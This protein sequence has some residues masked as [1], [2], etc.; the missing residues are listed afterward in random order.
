M[1]VDRESFSFRIRSIT[2]GISALIGLLRRLIR[3]LFSCEIL[4]KKPLTF[5]FLS[6]R[7]KALGGVAQLVERLHGMQ[8]VRGSIPLISIFLFLLERMYEKCR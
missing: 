5:Y 1:A 3:K 2:K 7:I 6:C 8:E 4:G